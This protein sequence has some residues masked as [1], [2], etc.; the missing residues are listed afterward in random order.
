[1]LKFIIEKNQEEKINLWFEKQQKIA[2]ETQRQLMSEKEFAD[3]TGNGMYSYDGAIGGA[4]EYKFIQT[5]L[6]LITKVSHLLTKNE[7]DVTDYDNW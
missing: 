4:L 6:G 1:M 2:I 3:L 7:L 5:S